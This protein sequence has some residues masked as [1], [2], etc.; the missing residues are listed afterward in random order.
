MYREKILSNY[1]TSRAAPSDMPY[2]FSCFISENQIVQGYFLLTVLY[3]PTDENSQFKGARSARNAHSHHFC[4]NNYHMPIELI[5][6]D[7]NYM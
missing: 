5:I 1:V 4:E 7:M 6:E 2:K 3:K